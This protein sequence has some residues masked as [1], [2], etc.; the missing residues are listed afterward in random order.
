MRVPP[1][2]QQL[3]ADGFIDEVLYQLMSGKEAEVY[4]VR[5]GDALRCAKIYKEANQRSFKQKTQYTEGRKTRDSRQARAMGKKTKFGMQEAE[6]EWQ[7]TEVETLQLLGRAGLRVPQTY[8][9]LD[10]VLLM[11]MVSDGEGN[12]APRLQEVE[13]SVAEANHIFKMLVQEVAKML[14]CGV[15]HGDL[16]EFNVLIGNGSFTIIDFPQ[17]VQATAGNAGQIFE[18]DMEHLTRYFG[19]FDPEISKTQYAKEIWQLFKTGQLKTDTELTGVF[20]ASNTSAN[21]ANVFEAIDGANDDEDERRGIRHPNRQ[22]H[23]PSGGRR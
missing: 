14:L 21:L 2:L 3:H 10:G 20:K 5:A 11:E 16:S 8:T 23:K 12:P 15:V 9:Y 19:K 18:R 4:V 6:N 1:R 13:F 22:P 7:N 17:A